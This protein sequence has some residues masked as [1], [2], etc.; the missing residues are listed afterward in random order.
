MI[1]TRI[2]TVNDNET[3]SYYYVVDSAGRLSWEQSSY[4]L[5]S[6]RRAPL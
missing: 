6:I 2:I 5:A 3:N 1:M 4:R